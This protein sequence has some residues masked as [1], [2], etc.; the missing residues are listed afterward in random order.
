MGIHQGSK[1][2]F[3]R[4]V[5]L[6][7]TTNNTGS[8]LQFFCLYLG[9][10]IMANP[11]KSSLAILDLLYANGP[12]PSYRDKLMLF[13]QFVGIWDMEVMFYDTDGR[14]VFHEPGEWA[15]SGSSTGGPSRMCSSILIQTTNLARRRIGT[16]LR[17][18]DSQIDA[19]RVIWIG[20]V[21]GNVGVMTGRQVGD[22]IWIEE[23]ENDG[24]LTRW[25]FT[26]ISKDQFHWKGITSTDG[27]SWK[28][29]QE[30][31]ARR[32]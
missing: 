6:E 16:T 28:M 22:E 9:A 24:S 4:T 26:E 12:S 27:I 14:R 31:L 11:D 7:N 8:T 18:Y 23:K 25:L 30:M 3:H 15:F 1:W 13:G 2:H 5:Q 21:S 29:E 19:W 32:R 20:V 10:G 17:F